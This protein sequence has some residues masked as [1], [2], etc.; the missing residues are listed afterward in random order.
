MTKYVR[1]VWPPMAVNEVASA[2]SFSASPL[3]TAGLVQRDRQ[4]D[5][6]DADGLDHELDEVGQRDRPHSAEHGVDDHH[7]PTEDD[8]E[9]PADVEQRTEDRRVCDGRGDRQHQRVAEHDRSGQ[10]GRSWAVT[11]FEHLA[12]GVHTQPLDPACEQQAQQQNACADGEHQPHAGDAVLVTQTDAAD[13]G[14]AA[15]H[16]GGHRAGVEHRTE[17][18]AGHQEVGLC[19]GPAL[20]PEPERDHAGEIDDDDSDI[21]G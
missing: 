6:E 20:A 14:C 4:Q 21:H 13:G 3:N 9:D 7:A 2:G 8:G 19:C 11:K 16:D 12:D 17:P 1:M 5:E 15:E 18:P 10:D